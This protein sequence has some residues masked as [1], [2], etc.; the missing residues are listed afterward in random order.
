M[1]GTTSIAGVYGGIGF[2]R[3]LDAIGPPPGFAYPA[4]DDLLWNVFFGDDPTVI[5]SDT[6]P[7][8]DPWE[9]QQHTEC[10]D[11]TYLGRRKDQW[12][13]VYVP[14]VAEGVNT[15]AQNE[16]ACLSSTDSG[17]ADIVDDNFAMIHGIALDAYDGNTLSEDRASLIWS[18]RSNIV[19]YGNTAPVKMLKNQGVLISLSTDWT[20]SGSMNLGRELVCADELNKKYFDD[21]F[22]DRELWLMVTY[23]PAIALHVDDKIG[24]LKPGLFADIV[25]YDGSGKENY[26]RAV[27]EADAKSTVLVLRRSSLPFPFVGTMYIGS[28]ALYGD[29]GLLQSLPPS[30]H[31][32]YAPLNG[33][34]DPLCESMDVCGVNKSVCPLRETWWAPQLAPYGLFFNPLSLGDLEAANNDSYPLFFCGE[35]EDEPTCVPSRPGEYNGT[36]VLN[37]PGKDRDGDG[38]LDPDD[39]CINVFNPIRPMDN[40]IQSDADGDGIGDACDNCPLVSNSDQTDTDGYSMGDACDPDDDNDGVLDENDA[41]PLEDAT[42]QD[43]NG[44][45]CIDRVENME[46]V[47]EELALPQGIETNLV[48]TV[49][50][51]MKSL[52]KGNDGAAVN[53]LQE[54]IN[55]VDAQRGKKISE[56]DAKMLICYANK[57]IAQIET[58]R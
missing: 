39:N 52:D 11:Y 21:A 55:K 23:N 22:S 16:F 18:P 2:S 3:N 38:I 58:G 15:A 41:C 48:S 46:T 10:S 32:V 24:S 20:P 17:G 57:A 14:H 5:V 47:I 44:D 4:F 45:G 29:A 56:Q 19:L 34:I 30:L 54:F 51:A 49:N 36:I 37:N 7:L 43:A 8:E 35:P 28:V 6:F 42:D 27:I 25:I 9:Y 40:G 26:Y 50:N 13:D 53:Q 1:T 31:D 12:T 33:I